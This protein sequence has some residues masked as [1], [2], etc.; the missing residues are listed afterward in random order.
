M[1]KT[2]KILLLI[3]TILAIAL[4]FC[5]YFLTDV[6]NVHDPNGHEQERP[7]TVYLTKYVPVEGYKSDYQPTRFYFF[8]ELD[9]VEIEKITIVHD[10]V[11]VT[12]KDSTDISYHTQFLTQYPT[13]NKLV[14]LLLDNE[15]LSLSL[16]NTQ[17]Q[18]STQQFQLDLDK[19]KYNY[20]PE[21]M[22]YKRNN[23]FKR[24]HPFG[25]VMV[26]PLN[27][28]LDANL[29]IY[30]KTGK[31]KYELGLNGFYYPTV[32]KL[33]GYDIYFKLR[34]EF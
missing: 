8:T 31:I 6:R 33:P 12:T 29:G 7:D 16:L 32:Q 22:T 11:R 24:L 5:I 4:G 17:G 25:E 13:A 1:N 19:F 14:Q 20:Q 15:S 26:R 10:T 27:L 28:M 23:F 2:T 21:G 34:Y 18:L 30:H 9:T 3:V